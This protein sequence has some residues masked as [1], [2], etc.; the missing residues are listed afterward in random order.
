MISVYLE[1]TFFLSAG[2]EVRFVSIHS[3]PLT[4]G[5]IVQIKVLY[6]VTLKYFSTIDLKYFQCISL[7]QDTQHHTQ[8]VHP[9]TENKT[10][11]KTVFEGKCFPLWDMKEYSKLSLEASA[12]HWYQRI[13]CIV[14]E[15]CLWRQMLNDD[16]SVGKF[17]N[18]HQMYSCITLLW[19]PSF[20]LSSDLP[21]CTWQLMMLSRVST[22][23]SLN[24][25]C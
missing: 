18:I 2:C 1:D 14:E 3:R 10:W 15:F 4:A 13:H 23:S 17:I 19:R 8:I 5:V 21:P 24:P 7:P 16:F 20:L 25:F 22:T 9:S 12:F 11:K 6:G